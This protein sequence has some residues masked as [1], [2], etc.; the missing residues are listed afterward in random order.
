[1]LAQVVARMQEVHLE[2]GQSVAEADARLYLL[3]DGQARV[4]HPT[5]S[6]T[7]APARLGPGDAFGLAALLGERT[8][9]VLEAVSKVDLVALDALDLA[10]LMLALPALAGSLAAQT[11]AGPR[12]GIR[13]SRPMLRPWP[14]SPEPRADADSSLSRTYASWAQPSVRRDAGRVDVMGGAP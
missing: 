7:A 1:D 8:G 9:G 6:E 14:V 3:T 13:L 4:L 5:G 2:P 10:H 12:E 11:S